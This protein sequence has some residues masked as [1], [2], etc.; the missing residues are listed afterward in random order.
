MLLW[1]NT[2][3]WECAAGHEEWLRWRRTS[4]SELA[5]DVSVHLEAIGGNAIIIAA[6]SSPR[7]CQSSVVTRNLSLQRRIKVEIVVAKVTSHGY[8]R[9]CGSRRFILQLMAQHR[10][11]RFSRIVT[12]NGKDIVVEGAS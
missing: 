3:R 12:P 5:D 6:T 2:S 7:C 11:V 4:E 10:R 1:Q 8:R 9:W